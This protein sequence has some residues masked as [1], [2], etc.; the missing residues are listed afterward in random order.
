MTNLA[1]CLT[2]ILV[3]ICQELAAYPGLLFVPH[4]DEFMQLS[5]C[6]WEA[7]LLL[8]FYRRENGGTEKQSHMRSTHI[9]VCPGSVPF[10]PVLPGWFLKGVP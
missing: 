1:T 9:L 10:M 5:Q 2:V 3:L 4:R 6:A 7:R 8:S